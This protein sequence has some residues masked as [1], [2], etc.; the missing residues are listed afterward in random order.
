M[1]NSKKFKALSN[2]ELEKLSKDEIK[3]Y[4]K[5]LKEY[6]ASLKPKKSKYSKLKIIAFIME[7]VMVLGVIASLVY[8]LLNLKK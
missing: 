6:K 7:I 8:P 1:A 5:Q 2:E 3:E 4:K